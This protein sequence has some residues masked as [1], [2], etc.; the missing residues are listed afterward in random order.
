MLQS[1]LLEP[2]REEERLWL[3]VANFLSYENV[4][5]S[6]CSQKEVNQSWEQNF[7]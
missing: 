1:L 7:L 2:N 4:P 3:L 5:K 6:I